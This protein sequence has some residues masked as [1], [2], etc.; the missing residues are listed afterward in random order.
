[1]TNLNLPGKGTAGVLTL[2]NG[3]TINY[4]ADGVQDGLFCFYTGRGLHDMFPNYAQTEDQKKLNAELHKK[5]KE[6]LMVS[7]HY[8]KIPV[9]DILM[10]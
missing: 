5:T 7:G 3:T 2:K 1:M 6:E 4:G 10:Y 9:T 8:A